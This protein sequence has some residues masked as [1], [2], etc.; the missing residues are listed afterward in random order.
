V[1]DAFKLRIREDGSSVVTSEGFSGEKHLD[2]EQV[3]AWLAKKLGGESSTVRN[4]EAHNHA[5]DGE[6][7]HDHDHDHEE[8]SH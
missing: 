3:R 2:A 4:T 1:K 5:H 7:E 6:H 8:H